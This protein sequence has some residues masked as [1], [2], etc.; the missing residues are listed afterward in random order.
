MLASYWIHVVHSSVKLAHA[1][2]KVLHW[3]LVQHVRIKRHAQQRMLFLLLASF[4]TN[5]RLKVV[6][7][8]Y[9]NFWFQVLVSH[10]R[11]F[12]P[13]C[14]VTSVHVPFLLAVCRHVNS[15]EHLKQIHRLARINFA[16]N[17]IRIHILLLI[18]MYFLELFLRRNP[19]RNLF[20]LVPC[21]SD[22]VK[23]LHILVSMPT[24]VINLLWRKV[25]CERPSKVCWLVES[26]TFMFLEFNRLNLLKSIL[27]KD[28]ELVSIFKFSIRR[29]WFRPAVLRIV[30]GWI[31][32]IEFVK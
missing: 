13:N 31:T 27:V 9:F 8:L 3:R 28:I 7:R 16:K 10:E 15:L 19:S 4:R 6:K 22:F 24:H 12:L 20:H 21:V 17:V 26:F 11:I 2:I 18:S 5:G 30:I 32:L 25:I 29:Y 1:V 14:G 23:V